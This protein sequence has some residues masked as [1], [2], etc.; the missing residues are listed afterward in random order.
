MG[1]GTETLRVVLN[2]NTVLSALLFPHGRLTWLRDE[3]KSGRLLPLAS[4]ATV[5]ELLRVLSYP[6]FHLDK[7]EIEILLGDYLP[8]LEIVGM[9]LGDPEDVP[10]CRDPDDPMFLALAVA[11]KAEALV[12]GDQAL[13]DLSD[14]AP[15]PIASPV[16]FRHR[17]MSEQK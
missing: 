5:R 14:K 10:Q 8:F 17:L 6:K 15:F 2:T 9:G 4:E 11:G 16:E 1:A 3:W 12:S 13:L 7:E